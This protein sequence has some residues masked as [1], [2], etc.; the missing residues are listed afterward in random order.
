MN[1]YADKVH[2]EWMR[3]LDAKR[4]AYDVSA[5][6]RYRPAPNYGLPFLLPLPDFEELSRLL[7]SLPPWR[8][9]LRMRRLYLSAYSLER[10][11]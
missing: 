4:D 8:P 9:R 7:G 6:T 10:F 3:E 1:D 5:F 2:A 11:K